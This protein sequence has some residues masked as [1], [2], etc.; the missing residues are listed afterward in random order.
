MGSLFFLVHW[1]W[2]KELPGCQAT[3]TV[4]KDVVSDKG[5]SLLLEYVFDPERPEGELLK[6]G[7]KK[8]KNI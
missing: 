4:G 2:E 5:V 3:P 7:K 6:K 8:N 1:V